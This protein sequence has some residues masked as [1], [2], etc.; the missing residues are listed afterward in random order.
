LVLQFHERRFPKKP[1]TTFPRTMFSRTTFPWKANN[2]V[3]LNYFQDYWPN[4][5]SWH[6]PTP[7]PKKLYTCRPYILH[8]GFS[9]NSTQRISSDWG[10]PMRW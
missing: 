3:S 7:P 2:D 4:L 9:G 5:S 6:S 1:N 8:F 10:V